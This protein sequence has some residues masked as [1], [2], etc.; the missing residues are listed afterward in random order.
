MDYLITCENLSIRRLEN[1]ESD[2]SMLAE[3]RNDERV[4]AYYGG[5]D[6]KNTIEE[7]KEKYVPRI[8]GKTRITPCIAVLDGKDSAYIQYYTFTDE[9]YFAHG[10]ADYQNAYGI[11]IFVSPFAGMNRGL[12]PKVLRLMCLYLFRELHA[13][14]V[15]ICPRK[16]NERAVRA[17]QKAGFRMHSELEKGEFFEGRWFEEHVMI[18]TDPPAERDILS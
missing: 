13:D 11:D 3:W 7:I 18:M 8:E 10:L 9:M 17:Y 15:E 5:R 14:V 16:V 2:L 6:K 4:S 12:G 1:T